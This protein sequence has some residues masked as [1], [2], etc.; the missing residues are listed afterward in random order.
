[1]INFQ[2]Q[3]PPGSF[4]EKYCVRYRVILLEVFVCGM[5]ASIS[6][7]FNPLCTG[8]MIMKAM[9]RIQGHLL[10][11]SLAPP[12]RFHTTSTHCAPSPQDDLNT[13][14]NS[15][16]KKTALNMKNHHCTSAAA[17]YEELKTLSEIYA[18]IS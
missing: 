5:N 2:F 17:L 4:L 3:K 6:N 15:R 9:H 13:S 12:T 1:M 14:L 11:R 7:H 10:P 18:F 8:L 16:K